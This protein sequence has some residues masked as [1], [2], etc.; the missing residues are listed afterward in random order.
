MFSNYKVVLCNNAFEHGLL[1]PFKFNSQSTHIYTLYD[2]LILIKIFSFNS[3]NPE[4]NA[5][6]AKVLY[7]IDFIL[8]TPLLRVNKQLVL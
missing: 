1:I 8:S 4:I 2:F 6:S 5:V 3:L 7:L